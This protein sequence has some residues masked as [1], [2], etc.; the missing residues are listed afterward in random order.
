MPRKKDSELAYQGERKAVV[1]SVFGRVEY[2]RGYYSGGGKGIAPLD[3]QLGAK[4][5]RGERRISRVISLRR[6]R[7][8]HLSR[9]SA[10]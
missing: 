5:R 9:G 10:F 7:V 2:R 1:I 6:D 3:E 8:K 4:P